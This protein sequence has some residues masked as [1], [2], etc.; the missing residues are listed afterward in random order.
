CAAVSFA[1]PPLLTQRLVCCIDRLNPP[2]LSATRP[3]AKIDAL[4]VAPD[5]SLWCCRRDYALLLT[6]YN[7]GAHVSKVIALRQ[8]QVRFS[9]CKPIN[10]MGNGRKERSIPLWSNTA[11]ELKTWFHELESTRTPIAFPSH[12]GRKLSHNGIDYILQ[13]VANQAE[14]TPEPHWQTHFAACRVPH[15][16]HV[17]TAIER[18]HQ[19]HRSLAWRRSSE[20]SRN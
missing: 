8:E 6:M 11:Q 10:L 18:R 14:Y 3:Y 2:L 9:G 12:H 20:H 1:T 19:S 13:Q 16:G 7:T 5:R 15:G 17:S 4:L